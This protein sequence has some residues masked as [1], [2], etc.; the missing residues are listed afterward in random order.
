MCT[1]IIIYTI[2]MIWLYTY[3]TVP[4]YGTLGSEQRSHDHPC[5]RH[6]S[7]TLQRKY[8]KQHSRVDVTQQTDF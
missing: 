5:G 7:C 1:C 8:Y 6:S 4:Q 3:V 2:L